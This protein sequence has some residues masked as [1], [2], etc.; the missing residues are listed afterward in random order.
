MP[1]ILRIL[2][3]F[4]L[5]GPV[6]NATYLS[7]DLAPSFETLLIGGAA[8]AEEKSALYIPE[9]EGIRPQIIEEFRRSVSP[10]ADYKAYRKVRSLIQSFGPDIVHTHASKAGAIGR[11]AALHEKVPVIVHTF[12]GHIFHS[13]F[14]PLKTAAFRRIE[15]YLA[16]KSDA[17][18]AISEQQ[19]VELTETHRVVS[20]DQI[21]MIP[22][23]FALKRFTENKPE[24]RLEF[25][26]KYGIR[27]D[28]FIIGIIG[29]FAAVKNHRMFI[30]T[31]ARLKAKTS[32][33]VRGILIGDGARRMELM[34]FASDKGLSCSG[35]DAHPDLIF[36]SWIE[37]ISTVLPGLD[38][39]LLTSHNEGTPVSLIEAQAAEV[40][41]LSTDVGGVRDIVPAE[42]AA[43][44]VSAGDSEAMASNVIRLLQDH[45]LLDQLARQGS[46]FVQDR[47]TRE[48]LADDMR[49]LYHELLI[50][51]TGH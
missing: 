6:Y 31:L 42:T 17:I 35:Q 46:A 30:D 44:L 16:G 5:G 14:H 21:R 1:K 8:E 9:S 10:L 43:L 49:S 37:D 12:H 40:A 13:Y 34:E 23:G 38:L 33:K 41:V 47:F 29:R 51:S 25:R 18:I 24:R 20:Q 2:N 19:R 22:L 45:R 27:E 11:L 50:K 36:T 48:R 26:R 32:R 4:N 3:R 7:A 28:E 15:H 39:V